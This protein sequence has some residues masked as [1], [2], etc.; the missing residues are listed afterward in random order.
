MFEEYSPSRLLVKLSYL[1]KRYIYIYIY[2]LNIWY[3]LTDR[4]FPREPVMAEVSI[5][6]RHVFS[7][8]W[9]DHKRAFIQDAFGDSVEHIFQ[10][11]GIF[12]SG[13]GWCYTCSSDHEVPRCDVLC[14]GPSCKNLSKEFAG[15]QNYANCFLDVN[16][17]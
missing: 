2:L 4:I 11:V 10:D 14:S 9:E 6:V 15:R 1:S 7:V 13:H 16:C 17:K 8:E 3:I 12:D 5:H